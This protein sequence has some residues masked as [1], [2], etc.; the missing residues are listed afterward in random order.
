LAESETQGGG[1]C[2]FDVDVELDFGEAGY[3]WV[4]EGVYLLLP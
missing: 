1:E 2:S 3:E 4:V